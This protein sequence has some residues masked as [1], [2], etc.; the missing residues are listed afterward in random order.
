MTYAV[1]SVGFKI[2]RTRY[3]LSWCFRHRDSLFNGVRVH[4]WLFRKPL[5][6]SLHF[7]LGRFGFE[8]YAIEDGR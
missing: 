5:H 3:G 8:L 6:A 2:R 4:R 7:N 1:H